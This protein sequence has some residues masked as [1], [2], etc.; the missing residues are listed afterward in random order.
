MIEKRAIG[1]DILRGLAILLVMSWHMPWIDY[2][3]LFQHIKD[4]GW[5][6]VDVFFV[7]SGFLI[8]TELLKPV[9]AGQTPELRV[10]YLKR[11]F[12]ILPVFWLMVA[13]YALFPILREREAMSPL[14]RYLTFTLNFGL[15]ARTFGTF[16][17]AWSLCV[18][19]HFYLILPAMV[20]I[21]QRFKT[22]WPAIAV[23]TFILIGDMVLRHHIWSV[24][25]VAGDDGVKFFTWFYYPSYTR[26]DGLLIGVCMA[27]LRLFYPSQ[28]TQFARPRFTLP[29]AIL[30]LSVT[31]YMNQMNG[32]I[33]SETGSIV[34]YPLFSLGIASLLASLLAVERHIQPARWTGLGYI[35]AISYSLYLSHKIVFH[36]DD[37][38]MPKAWMTGWS[39]IVIYYVTSITV[40]SILYFAVE[41][42]FM[43]MRNRLLARIKKPPHLP[44]TAFKS[45][46]FDN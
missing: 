4:F 8:G 25:H 21:L 17:H 40:A 23:A 30:C 33:L 9:H 26:L 1:P 45:T 38:F 42:T 7:L 10:F 37:L 24:W 14:W 27:A 41:R 29:L 13:I 46:T 15:D 5:L 18:E 20:L 32:V 16:T 44:E 6:G 12:R 2:P 11:A 43:Q 34:F 31:G 3:P 22:P 36:L 28:W 39:Q 19:E 35:A